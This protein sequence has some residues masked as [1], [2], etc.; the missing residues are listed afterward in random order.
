MLTKQARWI[1]TP[2]FIER[3]PDSFLLFSLVSIGGS[4]YPIYV[5][6]CSET[7]TRILTSRPRGSFRVREFQTCTHESK[8]LYNENHYRYHSDFHMVLQAKSKIIQ[9]QNSN[10]QYLTIPAALVK[11]SQYPFSSNQVVTIKIINSRKLEVVVNDDS[12][13]K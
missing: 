2:P 13:E 11:D 5:I 1:R 6:M 10:T 3:S 12:T 9:S 4:A 8:N 7:E